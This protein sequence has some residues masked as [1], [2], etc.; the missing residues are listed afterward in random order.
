MK[1]SI[2]QEGTFQLGGLHQDLGYNCFRETLTNTVTLLTSGNFPVGSELLIQQTL[3]EWIL[4][5]TTVGGL[6]LGTV[7]LKKDL[8]SRQMHRDPRHQS[9]SPSLPLSLSFFS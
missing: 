2:S 5:E 9:F 1:M 8:R 6:V 7:V 4:M 3:P